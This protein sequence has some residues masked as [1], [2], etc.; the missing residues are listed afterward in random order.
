MTDAIRIIDNAV[1]DPLVYRD[2]ALTL[3]FGDIIAGPIT[4][5]NMAPIGHNPLSAALEA[6]LGLITTFSAFRLSPQGQE[7]PNFLHTDRDMG[8]WTG[9]LYLNPDP[10]SGDGTDFFKHK[11]TGEVQSTAATKSDELCMEWMEWRRLD[12]WE[13]WHHVPAVFN[14]LLLF[15]SPYFHARAIFDNYGS[16]LSDSRLVQLCFGT[17]KL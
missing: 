15:P 17:G 10:P 3:P 16:G 7:E 8:D 2:H 6:D 14:R 1:P 12:L 9:I 4:F 5:H 13:V 11:K